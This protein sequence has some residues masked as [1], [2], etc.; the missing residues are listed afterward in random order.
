MSK[1]T[2]SALLGAAIGLAAYGTYD[3]TNQ[4]TMRDWPL[5][6]TVVDMAWGMVLSAAAASV[7]FIALRIFE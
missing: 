7:G 2:K 3:L 6:V 5:I 1:A 4:A